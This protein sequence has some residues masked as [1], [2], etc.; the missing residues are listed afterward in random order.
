M[1]IRE[2]Y[3]SF[4]VAKLLKEKGFNEPIRCWYD[5]Y[6]DFH[7]EGVIMRNEDCLPPTV[8]CPTHQLAMA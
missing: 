1:E 2:A 6:G 5:N 4:E 3:C 7:N 8:M